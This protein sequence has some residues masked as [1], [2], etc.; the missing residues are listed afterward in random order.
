MGVKAKADQVYFNYP[1]PK[2]IHKRMKL[3]QLETGMTIKDIL[4]SALV[5]YLDQFQGEEPTVTVTEVTE[6]LGDDL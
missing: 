3:Y 5:T 4:I 2:T 1:I 6:D